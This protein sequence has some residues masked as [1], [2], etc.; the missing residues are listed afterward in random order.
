MRYN[1]RDLY[2]DGCRLPADDSGTAVCPCC[3]EELS[4]WD[5]I[6]YST[7]DDKIVGCVSCIRTKTV[8]VED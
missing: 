1:G 5:E 3:G 4:L 8:E 6:Y 2:P 7:I